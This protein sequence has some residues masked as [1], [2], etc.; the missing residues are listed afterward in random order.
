MTKVGSWKNKLCYVDSWHVASPNDKPSLKN[1]Q[2]TLGIYGISSIVR[3]SPNRSHEKLKIQHA[4]EPK[5][6]LGIT[7]N[8][9]M[10]FGNYKVPK[11]AIQKESTQRIIVGIECF[12]ERLLPSWCFLTQTWKNMHHVNL[13]PFLHWPFDRIKNNQGCFPQGHCSRDA[14]ACS[15]TEQ[16]YK[17]LI[18]K[19]SQ[20]MQTESKSWK[21][22]R[23][24]RIFCRW[25]VTA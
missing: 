23:S 11:P 12:S 5:N 2:N 17:H 25:V 10:P 8:H 13:C 4:K 9:A 3:N 7:M 6:L 16:G 18:R 1:V 19:H 20:Y 14:A 24:Y 22:T 21:R 15:S